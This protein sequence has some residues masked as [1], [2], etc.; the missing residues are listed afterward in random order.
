MARVSAAFQTGR[1]HVSRFGEQFT[2][3]RERVDGFKENISQV[4]DRVI[5]HFREVMALATGASIVGFVE[6]TREAARSTTELAIQSR[7]LGIPAQ[8]LQALG[9]AAQEVGVKSDGLFQG[10][11]RLNRAL[12][13]VAVEQRDRILDL[14]AQVSQGVTT[15]ATEV[16][17]G[18]QKAAMDGLVILRGHGEAAKQ[19]FT[20]I[21][22]YYDAALPIAQRTRS[23][24]ERAYKMVGM[25]PAGIPTIKQYQAEFSNLMATSQKAREEFRDAGFKVPFENSA[26]V[27]KNAKDAG[28]DLGKM[29]RQ[30]G[31][32]TLD[33]A[34]K[35][36]PVDDVL[37]Q[38]AQ[39]FESATDKALLARQAFQLF[40][41]Q[42]A[43][44]IPVL[45]KGGH[46]IEDS[47]AEFTKLG[48]SFDPLALAVGQKLDTAFNRLTVA[49][50]GA[51]STILLAFAPALQPLIEG[52]T[53]F[54][55]ENA[56]TLKEWG[57][58]IANEAAP[59]I[60]GLLAAMRGDQ[61]PQLESVQT[62]VRLFTSLGTVAKFVAGVFK[63]AFSGIAAVLQPIAA[64]MNSIFGTQ[65]SGASLEIAAIILKVTGVF[66][67]FTSG[68]SAA[69]SALVLI[70]TALTS[71]GSG[72]LFVATLVGWPAIL[73]AGLVALGAYLLTMGGGWESF[74]T[75]VELT[76]RVIT[77]FAQWVGRGF[78]DLWDGA[79]KLIK[80]AWDGAFTW[81]TNGINTLTDWFDSLW[82]KV[83][84]V[85]SAIA[86]V[87]SGSSSAQQA[88][89]DAVLPQAAGGGL[90]R[91]PGT[92]TSDSILA[93][94][95]NGEFV[96]KTRA[97][98]H[99]GRELFSRLN[100]ME[101]P[102][103]A[104][105]GLAAFDSLGPNLGNPSLFLHG[106][107]P[108]PSAHVINLSIDGDRFDG[109]RAPEQT[110][111]NLVR[112]ARQRNVRS[113]GR[114]PGWAGG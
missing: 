109:L 96:V 9:A 77:A 107:A 80:S 3:L 93:R 72:L 45:A 26:E 21:G 42:Y 67:V 63:V 7:E 25:D 68:I 62:M 22:K 110:A 76:W 95:S 36:K 40:G 46:A 91:G 57:A 66:G 101:L 73:L 8:R 75:G 97:V 69:W 55:K 10:L 37:I 49:A 14:G 41:D 56:H 81:V 84:S 6:L 17:R 38:F 20:D 27:L 70:G 12:G 24:A 43:Q 31:I 51:G 18:G 44:I 112:F 53:G 108:E 59:A 104:E 50:K 64:L 113:A 4:A 28:A 89:P 65:F 60:S 32:E 86:G 98:M 58:A 61:G 111:T 1:E 34:G 39:R 48:I 105:G 106:M 102:R 88:A 54:I 5:P 92:A 33:A 2:Q 85:A 52:L 94:L 29:F 114:A 90:M 19:V 87:F 23:E 71:L 100:N 11:L 13:Q 99:Y 16:L 78:V 30:L 35:A 74:K 79:M 103:F 47:A 83:K 82:K 15:K